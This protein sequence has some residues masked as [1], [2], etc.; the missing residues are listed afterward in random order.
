VARGGAPGGWLGREGSCKGTV[1]LP[2]EQALA[3]GAPALALQANRARTKGS[4]TNYQPTPELPLTARTK[5]RGDCARDICQT[6]LAVKQ[7]S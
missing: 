4:R 7:E 6:S 2:A 1:C 5:E 3:E